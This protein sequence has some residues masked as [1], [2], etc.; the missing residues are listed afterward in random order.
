MHNWKK[1][2]I[3][4]AYQQALVEFIENVGSVKNRN[5]EVGVIG[6][7]TQANVEDAHALA[8]SKIIEEQV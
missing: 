7:Q 6:Q 5:V 1:T 2:K 8:P 3:E 4:I